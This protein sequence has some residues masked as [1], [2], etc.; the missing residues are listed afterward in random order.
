[1]RTGVASS[2][3]LGLLVSSASCDT[4]SQSECHRRAVER[5]GCCPVCDAECRAT[6]S[7]E[8]ADIHDTP[9]PGLDAEE[10][11]Q[12]GTTSEGHEGHEHHAPDEPAPQ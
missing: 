1:M 4:T 2:F 11:E 3:L 6:V 10:S 7:Q 9:L 8:C 5:F 12:T